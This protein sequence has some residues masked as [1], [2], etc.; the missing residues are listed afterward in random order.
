[1]YDGY[2]GK[3]TSDVYAAAIQLRGDD[4]TCWE[5]RVPLAEPPLIFGPEFPEDWFGDE[6]IAIWDEAHAQAAKEYGKGGYVLNSVTLYLR[7]NQNSSPDG[8]IVWQSNVT[9]IV[10]KSP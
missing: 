2:Y 5:E 9:P 10:P 3:I 8:E 7:D 6:V 1:M 4:D